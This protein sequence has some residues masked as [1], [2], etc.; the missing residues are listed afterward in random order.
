[1]APKRE[2]SSANSSTV[3]S[4]RAAAGAT[5]SARKSSGGGNPVSGL[6]SGLFRQK[7]GGN[8]AIYASPNLSWA[9]MHPVYRID[10]ERKL[11]TVYWEELP[12]MARVREVVEEAIAH[13]E[14]HP[15]LKFVWAL[16]PAYD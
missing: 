13:P 11:V 2:T 6:H 12:K 15:R 7:S 10:V 8:L 14:F 9:G 4:R 3:T 5:R 16:K 1:M